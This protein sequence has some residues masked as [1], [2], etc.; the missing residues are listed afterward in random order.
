M[1]A[2]DA[3]ELQ[4][5][6]EHVKI[7][8]WSASALDIKAALAPFALD[9]DAAINPP[10]CAMLSRAG[11][12]APGIVTTVPVATPAGQPKYATSGAL[13]KEPSPT[14]QVDPMQR[15]RVQTPLTVPHA[16]PAPTN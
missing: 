12:N 6:V 3:G 15:G 2:E 8:S 4:F 5:S 16:P 10:A 7:C 1:T 9:D 13:L 14:R 11:D